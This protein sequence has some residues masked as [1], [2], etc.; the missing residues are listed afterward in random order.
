VVEGGRRLTVGCALLRNW[1]IEVIHGSLRGHAL[2]RRLRIRPFTKK[3][4]PTQRF[5][6]GPFWDSFSLVPNERGNFDR[7]MVRMVSSFLKGETGEAGLWGERG[8]IRST[9]GP[10]RLKE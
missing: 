4:G 2:S 6:G 8:E 9:T 3:R 5:L 1:R 7:S 10:F